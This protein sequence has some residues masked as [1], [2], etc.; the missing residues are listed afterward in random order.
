VENNFTKYL[1]YVFILYAI[2]LPLSRAGISFLSILI[3]ILWILEGNLKEKI[4]I[5]LSYKFILFS[6]ILTIY[7]FISLAWSSSFTIHPI[8]KLWY[9]FVMFAICTSVKQKYIK[10]IIKAF[11]LSMLVS[12]VISYGIFFK[13]WTF[14]HGSPSDPTPFMNHLEYSIFLAFTASLLLSEIFL[15][16]DKKTKIFYGIFFMTVSTNL[17]LTGGRTGQIAYI[18]SLSLLFVANIKHK[19]LAVVIGFVCL[20]AILT[21]EYNISK[22]F[23]S[24]A[25]SAYCDLK[26]VI[27]NNN[28][29]GSWGLRLSTWVVSAKILEK[30]P[31][32]GTGIADLKKDY[33]TY[34]GK[35]K[36]L[37]IHD[38]SAIMTGGYHNDFLEATAGGGLIACILFIII[39]FKLCFVKINDKNIHNLKI[40]ILSIFIFSL[41]S[42]NFLRLQFSEN[43]FI[44]FVGIILA[45]KRLEKERIINEKI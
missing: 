1:N 32:F 16:N 17:F 26:N 30:N 36:I 7:L 25:D 6:I 20:S 13:L 45:Q 42:D 14:S 43:L 34:I 33:K 11:V 3:I 5:L 39:F 2:S 44:I 19:L 23:K 22:T 27:Q 37:N 18:I 29:G 38:F 10:Y 21:F 12:E 31:I 35:D 28:Y 8:S 15:S 4:K 24:R 9:Y 40:A 41:V